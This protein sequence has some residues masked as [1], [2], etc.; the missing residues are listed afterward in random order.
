M[1]PKE[2]AKIFAFE[3]GQIILG[4]V[5]AV[6]GAVL[7]WVV[8]EVFA[9]PNRL[10]LWIVL[11]MGILVLCSSF[12]SVS[13]AAIQKA[14]SETGISEIE[15][16]IHEGKASSEAAF[17]NVTQA[18]RAM[19]QLTEE[20]VKRQAELVPRDRIYKVMAKCI[21]EAKSEVAVITYLMADWENLTRTFAPAAVDTPHRG[22]FYDAIYE[23]IKNPSLQYLRVWQVPQ[24]KVEDAKALVL[25][26]ESHRK[27]CALIEEV[28]RDHPEQAHLVF[29]EQLTTASFILVDRRNLFFNIDFYEPANKVW[30]SPYMLF[31]KDAT[32]ES[33]RDLQGI[34]V[35]LTSKH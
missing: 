29:T 34:I 15:H 30:Y 23:A 9:D 31:V 4:I 26:D 20:V 3:R 13:L 8:Q 22:E 32:G 28:G 6:A 11:G 35:R 5:S 19:Q 17:A 33:F 18:N 10:E 14:R 1:I 7:G 25:G 16:L 12:V 24:G 21:R 2:K 27:E